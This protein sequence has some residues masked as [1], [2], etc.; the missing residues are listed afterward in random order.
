MITLYQFPI[1]RF[2][3]KIRWALNRKQSGYT[4]KN[5]LP[6]PHRR[7]CN[8]LTGASGYD[9]PRTVNKHNSSVANQLDE[10]IG[11]ISVCLARYRYAGCAGSVQLVTTRCILAQHLSLYAFR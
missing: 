3:E 2:R 5:L 10:G 6:G 8:K 7:E 1:S 11:G 4:V 9:I